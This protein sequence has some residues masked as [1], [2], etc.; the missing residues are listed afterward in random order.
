MC[1]KRTRTIQVVLDKASKICFGLKE[2]NKTVNTLLLSLELGR[3]C[4]WNK[5][6]KLGTILKDL[7]KFPYPGK[8]G[9]WASNTLTNIKKLANQE[10]N[11]D[12]DD[13]EGDPLTTHHTLTWIAS[14]RKNRI[15]LHPKHP[16]PMGT[17]E[18][19]SPEQK[20]QLAQLET[21]HVT[22][23]EKEVR[24]EAKKSQSVARYG[25]YELGRSANFVSTF[26]NIPDIT[27]GIHYLCLLRMNALPSL[28]RR[29]QALTAQK[30][31]HTFK[32]GI[33]PCC[34]ANTV[35]SGPEEWCHI[36]LTCLF[37][38]DIR[39]ATIG[40]TVLYL[41]EKI[42]EIP[43]DMEDQHIYVL[44][45]GGLLRTHIK[46]NPCGKSVQETYYESPAL[47]NWVNGYGHISHLYPAEFAEHGYVPVAPFLQAAVPKY[48]EALY[49]E[50]LSSV[51]SFHS[52]LSDRG[53]ALSGSDS[54]LKG[55]DSIQQDQTTARPHGMPEPT[56]RKGDG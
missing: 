54:F 28:S 25:R 43:G 21:F 16:S 47:T 26:I 10:S 24:R 27:R 39:D 46:E 6:P 44:L 41:I 5:G 48:T 42:W 53:K 36:L 55:P 14:M 8:E 11:L 7:I 34:K 1:Q 29:I 22:L 30:I 31:K 20:E 18:Q 32:K 3:I 19:V 49:V 40:G 33:C 2:T 51:D 4:L 50:G 37:F 45:M 35:D 13:E 23:L 17:N 9:T 52:S 12:E 15:D 56:S 38:Q